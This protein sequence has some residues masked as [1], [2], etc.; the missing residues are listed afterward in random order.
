MLDTVARLAKIRKIRSACQLSE[1][2]ARKRVGRRVSGYVRP[3]ESS[4]VVHI[5]MY[6]RAEDVLPHPILDNPAASRQVGRTYST[7]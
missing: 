3:V 5:L 2:A 1:G 7:S 6:C 4:V